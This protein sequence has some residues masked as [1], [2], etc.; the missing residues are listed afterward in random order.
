M[1]RT[2]IVEKLKKIIAENLELAIPESFSESS[3]TWEDLGVDSLMAMQL[4]VYIEE[5]FDVE[6]PE[7]EIKEDVFNT[8]GSLA[9][10]IESLRKEKV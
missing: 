3:R 8:I 10:F 2:E 1:N 7:D 9:D 5:D 6:V 4:I